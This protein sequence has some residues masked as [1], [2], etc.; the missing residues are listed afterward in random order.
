MD[1][2]TLSEKNMLM[3]KVTVSDDNKKEI[4]LV[5]VPESLTDSEVLYRMYETN[6][7]IRAMLNGNIDFS[8]KS[9]IVAMPEDLYPEYNIEDNEAFVV[10]CH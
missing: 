4:G 3:K 8:M 7:S 1:I 2:Y 9:E 10:C 6:P 5:L